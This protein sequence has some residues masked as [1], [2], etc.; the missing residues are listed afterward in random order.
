[1]HTW[2]LNSMQTL[3]I[4][5]YSRWIQEKNKMAKLLAYLYWFE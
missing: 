5:S 4:Q 2:V 1:M 3:A